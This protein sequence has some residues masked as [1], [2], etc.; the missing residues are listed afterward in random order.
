MFEKV[1]NSDLKGKKRKNETGRGDTRD[2]K[3]YIQTGRKGERQKADRKK[4]TDDGA[5]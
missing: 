1:R 4:R 2:R 5:A 3:C